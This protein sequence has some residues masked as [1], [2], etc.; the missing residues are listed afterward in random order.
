M[1]AFLDVALYPSVIQNNIPWFPSPSVSLTNPH[2]N[3]YPTLGLGWA[4]LVFVKAD[5]Y[6]K[7]RSPLG[8]RWRVFLFEPYPMLGWITPHP[9]NFLR[10]LESIPFC[11]LQ[12]SWMCI[13]TCQCPPILRVGLV[14][15]SWNCSLSIFPYI[16]PW[17]VF[18]AI[19]NSPSNFEASNKTEQ[20]RR[21][22]HC[23]FPVILMPLELLGVLLHNLRLYERLHH[24]SKPAN[25][26]CD[27]RFYS[28]S[29]PLAVRPQNMSFHIDSLKDISIGD[30]K[31]STP[32]SHLDT[33]WMLA[34]REP[35]TEGGL[36]VC[37]DNHTPGCKYRYFL[38]IT[39]FSKLSLLATWLDEKYNVYL[40][41]VAFLH[42]GKP[43][44]SIE[45]WIR[46]LRDVQVSK[47]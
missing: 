7:V 31:H 34:Q 18:C 27:L 29:W 11:F 10:T 33:R 36:A 15:N 30:R 24:I 2:I 28:S 40:Q 13:M 8:R 4:K 5:C 6:S 21:D 1:A 12:A 3:G 45:A 16:T 23:D 17:Q 32:K 22:L 47:S 42:K 19:C 26:I 9:L 44:Y 20:A 39:D 14:S 25:Q 41:Y 35:R 43:I 37:Y 38:P 46:N